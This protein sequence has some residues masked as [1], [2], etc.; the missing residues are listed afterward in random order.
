MKSKDIDT[1]YNQLIG[2][3]YE[4]AL[5]ARP[6]QSALPALREAMDAQ[7]VSLVLRPPTDNDQGVILNCIRPETG[8]EIT[9]SRLADSSD[10]EVSAYREQFFSLDPFINLPLDKVIALE[11]ILPDT[12][13]ISSDYYQHYLKPINLFRILGVDTAEPGGMIARL[14][15]SRRESEDGFKRSER[16]LLEFVTP[17]LRRAIEIYARLNRMTAER[18]VY[19]GAV[20]Q[21]SVASIILDEQG[22]LLTTNAVGRALLD[23]GAGLS[24]RDGRLMIEGREFN[25]E[26]QSALATIIKAQQNGETSV[27]RALRV[28]RPGVRSDLGLVIKPVPLSE[29]SEGQSSPSA[30]V[31][32]SDPDLKEST[33]RQVLGELF[34]LTPAEAN[35]ATLLAR[36]LS[37]AQVSDAQHISQHTARAQ[38]KSIFAKMGVSRQAE[39]VRLVLKSVASLG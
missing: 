22:K 24:L 12:E 28:P 15:I 27:V 21:L 3:V 31:F 34:E 39:L 9:S 20:D 33:S 36:G 32:I 13:L 14:R 2:L 17:H 26:L 16:E 23:Q 4:G 1:D 38:L 35:L 25:K 18:D 5:E 30:A 10:W 29:W 8:S 11:D 6:W 7:V 19:A 37:L